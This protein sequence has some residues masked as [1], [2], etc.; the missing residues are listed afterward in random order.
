MH[1]S[2]LFLVSNDNAIRKNDRI[3]GRETAEV[4]L[5]IFHMILIK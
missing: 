5:I 3:H 2:S 4:L 1:V